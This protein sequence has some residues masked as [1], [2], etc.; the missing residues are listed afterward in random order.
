MN[1]NDKLFSFTLKEVNGER[2]YIHDCLVL[3]T[4]HNQVCKKAFAHCKN[5]YVYDPSTYSY[6]KDKEIHYFDNGEVALTVEDLIE[7][8]KK[9]WAEK[10]YTMALI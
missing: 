5:W 9:D 4:G 1:K 8:T 2:T 7:T 3:A 6:D 10:A